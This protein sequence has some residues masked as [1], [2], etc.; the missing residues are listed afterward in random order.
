MVY[1]DATGLYHFLIN[2]IPFISNSVP[3]RRVP[4]ILKNLHTRGLFTV[5]KESTSLFTILY[6]LYIS[7]YYIISNVTQANL[8]AGPYIYYVIFM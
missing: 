4:I 7:Y 5:Q 8:L 2:V 1:Q 6:I 3:A